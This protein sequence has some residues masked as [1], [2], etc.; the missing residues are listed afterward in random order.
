MAKTRTQLIAAKIRGM[1]DLSANM[2]SLSK[3]VQTKIAHRSTVSGARPVRAE[4][5]ANVKRNHS[6]DTGSLLAAIIMKRLAKKE[7]KLTS[8]TIVTVRGRARKATKGKKNKSRGV[9]AVAPYGRFIEFGT[10]KMSPRPFL[11]P[12]FESKKTE[13]VA[14]MRETLDRGIAEATAKFKKPVSKR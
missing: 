5:K 13:A 4:A 11:K 6:I 12:A 14:K 1:A 2:K 10:V 3:D 7:T 9:A 8:E